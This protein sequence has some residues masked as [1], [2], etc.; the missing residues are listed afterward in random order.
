MTSPLSDEI[1]RWA[2]LGGFVGGVIFMA[3]LIIGYQRSL[4]EDYRVEIDR[5]QDEINAVRDRTT[6]REA[7]LM[8]RIDRL[9]T[10]ARDLEHQGRECEARYTEIR[11]KYDK[12]IVTL[13]DQGI[14][15]PPH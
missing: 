8:D 4:V 3:R 6:K 13:A 9:E 11:G 1:G 5:L 14:E 10:R 12:L 15:P 2:G 7:E